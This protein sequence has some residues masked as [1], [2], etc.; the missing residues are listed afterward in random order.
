MT[1][2]HWA[3]WAAL[4]GLGALSFLLSFLQLGAASLPVSMVIAV[5]MAFVVALVFMEVGAQRFSVRMTL[6]AALAFI[7]LLVGFMCADVLTRPARPVLPGEE[8]LDSTPERT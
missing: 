2:G 6:V 5:A 3:G 1:L 8:S 4:L 7:A